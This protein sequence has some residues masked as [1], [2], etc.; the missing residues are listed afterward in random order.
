MSFCA[1]WRTHLTPCL[2]YQHHLDKDWKKVFWLSF[3]AQS[4]HASQIRS[5]KFCI[6]YVIKYYIKTVYMEDFAHKSTQPA[7]TVQTDA[8]PSWAD[9][10]VLMPCK[11]SAGLVIYIPAVNFRSSWSLLLPWNCWMV[12]SRNVYRHVPTCTRP[13]WIL[14]Y[15][16]LF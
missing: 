6:L 4:W 11:L 12:A 5:P 8:I 10:L 3:L 1:I 16:I 9:L 13:H 2:L 15:T 14:L 7:T